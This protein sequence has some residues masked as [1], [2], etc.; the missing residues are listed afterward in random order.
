MDLVRVVHGQLQMFYYTM[1]LQERFS[2]HYIINTLR[3]RQNGSHFPDDIL[4]WIFLNTNVWIWINISLKFVLRCPIN[5][6][7][8]LVQVMA[9]CRPGNKPLFEPM[10]ARLPTHICVTRPQWVKITVSPANQKLCLEVLLNYCDLRF[11]RYQS[12]FD[13]IELKET[14]K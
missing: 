9:W 3:L 14:N 13:V 8:T 6:I 7:P 1:G 5:N 10:M 2:L 4:K 12:L 11:I